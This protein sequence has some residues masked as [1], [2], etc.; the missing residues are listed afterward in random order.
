MS[1]KETKR[2]YLQ[3]LIFLPTPWSR[4]I[5]HSCRCRPR[6]RST[7]SRPTAWSHCYW[8]STCCSQSSNCKLTIINKWSLAK[9]NF[10]CMSSLSWSVQSR[11]A[12]AIN[13]LKQFQMHFQFISMP[14]FNRGCSTRCN[15]LL[16]QPWCKP[17]SDSGGCNQSDWGAHWCT[18]EEGKGLSCSPAW[19]EGCRWSARSPW[20]LPSPGCPPWAGPACP[21][22]GCAATFGL[23]R[24]RKSPEGLAINWLS[25]EKKG[26]GF[27]LNDKNGYLGDFH[28]RLGQGQG[29]SEGQHPQSLHFE[30]QSTIDESE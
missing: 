18:R 25:R 28:L 19:R 2:K 9:S 12:I 8:S 16:H 4:S 24:W 5:C 10:V 23:A 22:L 20:S 14:A 30:V 6:R 15:H 7:S 13:E 21:L 26:L 17:R 3:A 1:F 11:Y 27:I 29:Q